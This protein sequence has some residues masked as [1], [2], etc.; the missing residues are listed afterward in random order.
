MGRLGKALVQ[1]WMFF[2]ASAALAQDAP[3]PSLE[4]L[5]PAQRAAATTATPVPNPP[6]PVPA[7]AGTTYRLETDVSMRAIPIDVRFSGARVVMFGSATT[8]GAAPVD[9]GP[10]DVAAVVQSAPSQLTV[11]RKSKVWGLWLNTR[12]IDFDQ[13]PRYYAVVSTRPLE[14][15]AKPEVLAE[16]GIGFEQVPI[17]ASLSDIAGVTAIQLDEFRDA[18]IHLG[19]KQKQ[20][21]RHDGG[22]AFVGKSLFRGQIDLPATV[23]VGQLDVSVF[24]FRGGKVVARHENRVTLSRQG[25]ENLTYEF[26]HRHALLY[27]LATVALA[28][29]VGLATSYIVSLRQR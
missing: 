2:A 16:Y 12:S 21:V 7:K 22:I 25:F 15:V 10:L 4:V 20:Y 24:L 19:I 1:L 5:A 13:A 8:I 11:R 27:G 29:L 18:A 23:P 28:T 14:A 6:A 26:A 3:R 17:T 9:A